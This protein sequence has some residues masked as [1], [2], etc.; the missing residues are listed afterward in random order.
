[1]KKI[2]EITNRINN[3]IKS[4]SVRLIGNN[5]EQGIYDIDVAMSL[6]NRLD[7]DLIEINPK[8]DPPVCKI[9]DFNKFLYDQKKKQKDL[10]KKNKSNKIEIKEIR[11]T[12]NTDDHDYEFK[13]KHIINFIKNGDKVKTYVFFKGREIV[14]KSR[15]EILLLKLAD[16]LSDI[17]TV[18]K[19]PLL[20][21]CRMTI[22]LKPKK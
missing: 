6:A 16:E 1:M 14:H 18:E 20:E 12:P 22:I 5:I 13:K 9:E 17:A 4:S 15:G 19:M 8:A 2:K 7:L 10:D 21:G 3:Q 11:F